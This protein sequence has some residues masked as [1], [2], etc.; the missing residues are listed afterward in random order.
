M[1]K[2]ALESILSDE[3]IRDVVSAFDQIGDIIIV[4]IPDSLIS[5]KKIIGIN[6][7]PMI[8]KV[9][10]SAFRSLLK[11]IWKHI[12]D[13]RIDIAKPEI[14]IPPFISFSLALSLEKRKCETLQLNDTGEKAS[15]AL[16]LLNRVKV[17]EDSGFSFGY[18]ALWTGIQ[19]FNDDGNLYVDRYRLYYNPNFSLDHT[20]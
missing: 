20:L 1:L 2:K 8:M 7:D 6:N 13:N 10:S 3:D 18:H 17:N 5:K 16:T 15:I 9:Q 12:T 19:G 14:H 4:R 11:P